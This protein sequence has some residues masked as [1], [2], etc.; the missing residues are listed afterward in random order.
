[1]AKKQFKAESKRL[2][3]LMINSIYTHK[4]IFLREI[5]SNAS[6]ALDKLYYISLTDQN[7]GLGRDDMRI[8]ITADKA[9][10]TLTVSD[11]G[12]GMTEE[13]LENNLGVIASSGTFKFKQELEAG[14]DIESIGQFG[15]GFYSAFMVSSSVK[16]ITRRYGSDQAYCWESSGADGYTVKPCDKESVGT[17]VI[18]TMKED[19]EDDKFSEYLDEYTIRNLVK[20]YSDY[21]RYP[22]QCMMTHSHRKEGSPDDKP[23]YEDVQELETLN[24]MVPIWQR[25]KGQVTDEE[26]NN[27]YMQAFSDYAA[28]QRVITMSVEG[29]VSFKALLFIPS[30]QPYDFYMKDFEKGLKLYSNGVMIMEKCGDL[31]PDSFRFVRGLVDSPDLSLNISREMLQ[32]DRQL[33]MIEKSIEKKIRSELDKMLANE[34]EEYEKFYATFGRSLKYQAASGFGAQA[35][36]LAD[37]LLFQSSADGKLV[38]LTE[39]V[40]AMPEGQPYI[41]YATGDSADAIK[42]L[43]QAELL[44]DK[45]YAMLCYT[46]EVDEFVTRLLGKYKDK[47]F[48]SVNNDD[49]GIAPDEKEEDESTKTE[50]QGVANFVKETLGDA[51]RDVI[52]SKKLKSHPVCL[53]AGEGVSFEMEKY[54]KAAQPETGIKADRILELNADHPVFA[55]LSETMKTDPVKAA[56][57]ARILFAQ[58]QL[59]AGMLPDDPVAYSDLICGIM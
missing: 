9:A 36:E 30:Q 43:P 58:A 45:G 15:V 6:D 11:N 38:T 51:V 52:I 17:D 32:H 12:V 47:E 18:M 21:V 50:R 26:Y 25:P 48:R 40:D 35:A 54:F 5:I 27:F 42:K 39:Y 49:L 37:L 20:K 41:Y 14:S 34:R 8:T 29:Q 19:T 57:Y 1:M 55:R 10:R 46:E 13:D 3:D 33:R 7:V 23:E 28:P 22:I 59:M 24:S 4:E 56:D 44:A 31:L 2:L 16:V 53:S